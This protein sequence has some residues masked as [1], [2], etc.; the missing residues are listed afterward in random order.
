[1]K[2]VNIYKTRYFTGYRRCRW[3]D[4]T[5]YAASMIRSAQK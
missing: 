5:H 3:E 1:M 4:T 2:N